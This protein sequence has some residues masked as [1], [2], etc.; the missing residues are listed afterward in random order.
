M[1]FQ[2]PA[3]INIVR[4]FSNLLSN[5][6]FGHFF[7]LQRCELER[8][9][10]YRNVEAWSKGENEQITNYCRHTD[11]CTHWPLYRICKNFPSET[12][13]ILKEESRKYFDCH[14]NNQGEKIWFPDISQIRLSSIIPIYPQITWVQHCSLRRIGCRHVVTNVWFGC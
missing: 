4:R 7:P 9:H 13:I 10:I 8:P 3:K 5:G 1:C 2:E 6:E 14:N 11:I 12:T